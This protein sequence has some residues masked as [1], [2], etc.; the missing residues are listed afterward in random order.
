MHRKVRI[1][2]AAA[3]CTLLPFAVTGCGTSAAEGSGSTTEDGR[4]PDQ[5]V[6]AAI[7]SEDSTTLAQT[8]AGVIKLLEQ[9]TGKKVVMQ[10]AT[11]YA[12]VIEAQRAH[13]ADIAG[14]GPLSYIVAK[15]SG[16]GVEL[17]GAPVPEKGGSPGYQSNGFTTAKSK[18]N[19]LADYKGKKI[20]FVDENSTS[21]YLYPRAALKKAGLEDGDYTKVMAGGHD[22]SVLAV[23]SGQCDAGFATDDMVNRQLIEQ[24]KIKKGQ[25]KSVWKSAEIPGSPIA[26][27]S[28]LTPKLKQQI[29]DVFLN[30]ANADYLRSKG[31]CKKD[32]DCL[33]EGNWGYVKV[34]DSDYKSVR[35]VCAATRDKQCESGS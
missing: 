27:S 13:K 22:A 5:L 21:G 8:Y 3:T 1:A 34:Q 18:I 28:D 17:V 19:S 31:L 25:L 29:D 11:S 32:E 7:P 26:I 4:D 9:K 10:K 6:F 14:Y 20:C 30:E 23:A 24:G 35:D 12:A 16:A 15:D 33:I 2:F